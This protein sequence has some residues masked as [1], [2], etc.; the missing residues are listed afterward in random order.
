MGPVGNA[1]IAVAALAGLAA[2]TRE[3]PGLP[4]QHV[5]LVTVENLRADRCS[6]LMHDRP[7]TFVPGVPQE[8]HENRAFGLDDLAATGVSFASCYAPSPISEVS[9]ASLMTGRP[10]LEHGLVAIDERLPGQL[11]T[12]GEVF[13]ANGFATAAFLSGSPA[14]D[15][16]L[17]QGFQ[18]VETHAADLAALRAASRWLSRDPGAGERTF[19]WIH[20]SGIALPWAPRRPVREAEEM[21]ADRVFVDPEYVGPADGSQVFVDAVNAGTAQLD[22]L[23]RTAVGAL[24]DREVAAMTSLLW[25][26]LQETYDFHTAAGEASETWPRTVFVLAGVQGMELCEHGGIGTAGMLSEQVLHVPLVV[27]HPDSLTGERIFDEVVELS[28]VM[29]TLLDWFRLP[30]PAGVRGRSLLPRTD[31]YVKRPFERRPVFAQLPERGVF[32]ARTP[33]WHLVWNAL[34]AQPAGRPSSTPP[35]PV[36]ALYEPA[37]DPDEVEDVSARHPE[38]VASLTAAIRAWREAQVL[39]PLELRPQPR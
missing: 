35:L 28:D 37:L 18:V 29:P 10:P 9:L 36:V 4:P 6:F 25:T 1:L 17:A 7:T 20:L 14:P 23:D 19:V 31:S 15:A 34:R 8:R 5:L 12:L 24:Y 32:S 27:R 11:V 26:G 2:C 21:L 30:T 3:R 38:V 22:E 16:S 39:F 13:C 33:R